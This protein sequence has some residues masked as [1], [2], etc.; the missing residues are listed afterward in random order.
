VQTI[1][2]S[3]DGVVPPTQLRNIDSYL[4]FPGFNTDTKE[5]EF[6]VFDSISR[7]VLSGPSRANGA[8]LV[9]QQT[10]GLM[11]Y[12]RRARVRRASGSF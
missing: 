12:E 7:S 4:Q 9:L 11:Q 2:F 6:E 1:V 5:R 10:K 3:V 8:Y